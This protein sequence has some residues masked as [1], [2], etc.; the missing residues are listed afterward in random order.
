VSRIH[1][2]RNFCVQ[3]SALRSVG[4]IYLLPFITDIVSDLSPRYSR[5][6]IQRHNR[7][8]NGRTCRLHEGICTQCNPEL[9]WLV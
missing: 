8:A 1:I 9:R 7:G 3:H 5:I 4:G 6:A 2:G